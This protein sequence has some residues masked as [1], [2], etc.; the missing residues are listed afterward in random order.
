[1]TMPAHLYHAT[2]AIYAA[3]I[4]ATG[5]QPRSVGGGAVSPYLCMSGTESGA[6]TL[7]SNSSDIIFR[8]KSSNLNASKWI[9]SGAG[10]AEWRSTDTIPAVHLQYRRR[11]A[12]R[13]LGKPIPNQWRNASLYPLGT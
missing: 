9:K 2:P 10:K 3:S 7:G 1:M 13:V 5:L 11:M 12:K 4:A 8:V 6:A